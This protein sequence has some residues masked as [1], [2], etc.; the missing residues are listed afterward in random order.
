MCVAWVL[1]L[2]SATAWLPKPKMATAPRNTNPKPAAD[3]NL[4]KERS[5]ARCGADRASP[6]MDIRGDMAQAY[7]PL[8]VSLRRGYARGERPSSVA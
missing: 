2:S 3:N 4:D 1:A 7:T 8:W 5:F 6:R